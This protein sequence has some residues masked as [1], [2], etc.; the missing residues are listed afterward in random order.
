[1]G[2]MFVAESVAEAK[3]AMRHGCDQIHRHLRHAIPL[4]PETGDNLEERIDKANATIDSKGVYAV[5][6]AEAVKH[7]TEIYALSRDRTARRCWL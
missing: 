4:R 7:A 1:M 3:D 2:Q 5:Q 6:N